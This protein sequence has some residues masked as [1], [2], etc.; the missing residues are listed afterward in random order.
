[1]KKLIII[2]ILILESM[3]LGAQDLHFSQIF[4]TPLLRNP[5]LAGLFT[6]DIRVQSVYRN[7]WNS[8]TNPYQTTS[9]SGEFKKN[10]GHGNDFVTM[11]GQVLYD[12]AGSIAMTT[13]KILPAL[14]Y[15]KTLSEEKNIYLCLG[16]M[17]GLVQRRFD[18]SKV[19]TNNQY[20]GNYFNSN[21]SDGE[22]FTNTSY[23]YLDGSAGMS[24]NAQLGEEPMN[25]FFA[26]VAYHHFNKAKKL[27]FYNNNQIEMTP[28][29]V[30]SGGV[31]MG[32]SNTSYFTVQG[33]YSKQG[34]QQEIIGGAL[35]S[36][37]LDD[38]ED[39]KYY[40][41]AGAYMRWKDA[42]IPVAKLECRPL[43]V[44]VSYD[45]NISPLKE[46]SRAR[47]GFEVAITYQCAKKDNSSLESVRC[48]K[49]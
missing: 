37:Q 40:F 26:G 10:V 48:P 14:N 9:L 1:M 5:A 28:K 41:H 29:W 25:N 47:G 6:G 19:T 16:F 38:Y 12:K 23:S 32:I 2:S 8:V 18:R 42:L 44:S 43:S 15:Q 13:T 36:W 11:G 4:E 20:D 30:V 35:F 3:L 7:Q 27:S 17:G 33:D 34:T 49:F 31:R 21:L 46:V 45:A 39:A 24:I 22:T